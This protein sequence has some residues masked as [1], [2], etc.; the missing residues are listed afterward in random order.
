MISLSYLWLPIFFELLHGLKPPLMTLREFWFSPPFLRILTLLYGSI[1]LSYITSFPS[2][3][4]L[5]LVSPP[6][7]SEIFSSIIGLPILSLMVFRP[8][9]LLF[10]LTRLFINCKCDYDIIESRLIYSTSFFFSFS[11]LFCS[12]KSSVCVFWKVGCRSIGLCESECNLFVIYFF[13]LA[14]KFFLNRKESLCCLS[15]S[16]LNFLISCYSTLVIFYIYLYLVLFIW[17]T[18]SNCIT[19]IGDKELLFDL[20]SIDI[21]Y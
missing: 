2:L 18:S 15:S 11:S 8:L 3:A 13:R 7:S 4:S 1:F 20:L 12:M 14:R 16:N 6:L 5:S 9:N 17:T 21:D 19:G 10:W